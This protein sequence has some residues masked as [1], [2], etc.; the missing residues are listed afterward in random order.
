MREEGYPI[1]V[2]VKNFPATDVLMDYIRKRLGNL[3]KFSNMVQHLDVHLE[4]ERGVYKGVGILKIKG[5]TIRVEVKGK[6]PMS[7]VDEM[8]D[9]LSREVKKEKEK[10]SKERRR[11]REVD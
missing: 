5:K 2:L 8:K 3:D 6:D 10:I 4:E 11:D 1:N 9:L 7:A